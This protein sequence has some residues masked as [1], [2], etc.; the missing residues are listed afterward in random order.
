[1]KVVAEIGNIG[2]KALLVCENVEEAVLSIAKAEIMCSNVWRGS[3]RLAAPGARSP[4]RKHALAEAQSASAEHASSLKAGS[5]LSH[6]RRRR[7]ENSLEIEGAAGGVRAD[8]EGV[9]LRADAISRDIIDVLCRQPS[10][11]A[12]GASP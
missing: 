12:A 6:A 1:M 11:L 2:I 7:P 5:V 8:R 10:E 9:A 4:S 3:G